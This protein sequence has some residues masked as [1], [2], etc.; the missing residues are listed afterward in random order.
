MS[1]NDNGIVETL[2]QSPENGFR[3]LIARWATTVATAL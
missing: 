2:K 3:M 1:N